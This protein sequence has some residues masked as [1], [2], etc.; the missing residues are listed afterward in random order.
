VGGATHDQ[1]E[2]RGAGGTRDGWEKGASG[3]G[4]AR[5]GRV[6]GASERAAQGGVCGGRRPQRSERS[7]AWHPDGTDTHGQALPLLKGGVCLISL[8]Q[9][10]YV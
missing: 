9:E 4:G 6:R 8:L 10:T 2:E 7:E 3:A 1:S 5:D